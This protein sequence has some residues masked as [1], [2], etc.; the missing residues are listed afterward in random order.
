MRDH[1]G[2]DAGTSHEPLALTMLE[3]DSF[4]IN[5]NFDADSPKASL[6]INNTEL[7]IFDELD[8]DNDDFEQEIETTDALNNKQIN[9]PVLLDND[10]FG[11]ITNSINSDN[12]SELDV[13]LDD[14]A[15]EELAV[16]FGE[17][18]DIANINIDVNN[19]EEQPIN[20]LNEQKN[21]IDDLSDFLGEIESTETEISNAED[22]GDFFEDQ[23]ESRQKI[24]TGNE[25]DD[26]S[27]EAGESELDFNFNDS[28][29][30][31]LSATIHID[32]LSDSFTSESPESRIENLIEDNWSDLEID[33]VNING[34]IEEELLTTNQS[35]NWGNLFVNTKQDDLTILENGFNTL[36]NELDQ[37]NL[38]SDA[39]Q[40][41]DEALTTI[42]QD[43]LNLVDQIDQDDITA[44]NTIDSLADFFQDD[45]SDMVDSDIPESLTIDNYSF[46]SDHDGEFDG[47]DEFSVLNLSSL[48]D[49]IALDTESS[50]EL[51]LAIDHQPLV[52]ELNS[53]D[54]N[55][56]FD[57]LE[58]IIGDS[59]SLSNNSI[60][61][62]GE[63][64]GSN[65]HHSLDNGPQSINSFDMNFDE[66]EAL[67]GNT[68][69]FDMSVDQSNGKESTNINASSTLPRNDFDEL[70]KIL[71]T[72]FAGDVGEIKTKRSVRPPANTRKPKLSDSTMR[73]DVKYL[74]SLNNLVGELVVN[75]NLLEQEQER[76]Q[77][78]IT[79]LLRQVQ[80]LSD[81]SQRMRDQYDRSLLEASLT[82]GRGRSYSNN[83]ESSYSGDGTS[84]GSAVSSEFEGIEFDRYNTF[85]VLSQEIIELIVKVRESASDIES[86]ISESSS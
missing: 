15:A 74:D 19:L 9:E 14:H 44:S 65:I 60:N 4:A 28:Q 36:S 59:I 53:I 48:Q 31:N 39:L 68:G 73:V 57:D 24:N 20:E 30:S 62:N 32:G 5:D 11:E 42:Q 10:K 41:N 12:S 81:V 78:F 79:N 7:N 84:T 66:L 55:F 18:T 40:S 6:N 37:N 70:E 86:T 2:E 50:K 75:R 43:N 71:Q 72:R 67:L 1:N 3:E 38:P 22:V 54:D 45:D 33:D 46:D 76:L 61:T 34:N 64:A 8:F 82:A 26:F 21:E 56:N 83:F 85:H 63:L 17:F 80:L 16:N 35:D 25:S 23:E 52:E 27:N 51:N 58:A 77:Q 29:S 47:L 49:F 13:F 69:S